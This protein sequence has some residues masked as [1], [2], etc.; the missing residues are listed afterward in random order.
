MHALITADAMG[1]VWTYVRELVTGLSRRGVRVT[2][3]SFGEIPTAA[4]T[5]WMESLENVDF[6][7]T[8]FR[9]EW[10]QDVVTDFDASSEYLASIVR[11]VKP[12][13]LHLNQYCYGD[14]Q[15]DIPIVVVAHSDVVSWW[16][17]VHGHQPQPN[18]WIDWYR[19]VVTRGIEGADFVVAP[20]TWM[21]E[22][23]G[24]YYARPERASVIYNGR[25]HQLFNPLV[26]KQRF[27]LSVGRLW[28][29]GK[30]LSLFRGLQSP[31][32]VYVA[33]SDDH[34]DGSSSSSIRNFGDA[35]K[36]KGVQNE[37]QLCKLYSRASIYAAVS[38]YEPFGLALLEAAFSRCAIV[39]NDIPSFR[40]IWGDSICYFRTNDPQDL[41]QKIEWLASDEAARRQF[42]QSSYEHAMARY[43]ADRMVE[44]YLDLYRALVPAE[45]AAA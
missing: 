17:G 19:I 2:L 5:A 43:T 22:A 25:N 20:S 28:D 8:A 27:A 33:G 6:R 26:T 40:E 7:P 38:R 1:G 35:I 45:A 4:Q 21:M 15:V 16:V 12:D 9:L 18:D 34:P 14:L 42:G 29:K 3:V 39:A 44:Q 13:I 30:Q 37:A 10:M 41:E 36:F 24:S 31:I 11:E 23:L 32:P